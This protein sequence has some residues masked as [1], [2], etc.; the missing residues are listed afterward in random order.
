MLGHEWRDVLNAQQGFG[1]V[2][3][4]GIAAQ[5]ELNGAAFDA[6]ALGIVIRIPLQPDIGFC[7][8]GSADR[9]VFLLW[10]MAASDDGEG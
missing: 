2:A 3:Q 1:A 10:G 8:G 5:A 4:E 7:D 6:V 9:A